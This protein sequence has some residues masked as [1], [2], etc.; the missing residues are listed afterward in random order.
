[1]ISYLL[2]TIGL[3]VGV[4]SMIST[5]VGIGVVM[6]IP[7]GIRVVGVVVRIPIGVIVQCREGACLL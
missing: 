3:L 1:M 7:I 6:Q 2:N 4:V 5:P